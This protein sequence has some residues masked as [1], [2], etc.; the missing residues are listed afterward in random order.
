M[1]LGTRLVSDHQYPTRSA[2]LLLHP[3]YLRGCHLPIFDAL[4]SLPS[5]WHRPFTASFTRCLLPADA[6]PEQLFF[7][8]LAVFQSHPVPRLFSFLVELSQL[9]REML[10]PLMFLPTFRNNL[11]QSFGECESMKTLCS[12]LTSP[13][14]NDV[15][16][17]RGFD[18]SFF[19]QHKIQTPSLT[20][21]ILLAL[22]NLVL[23]CPQAELVSL[24]RDR[25]IDT[26][27]RCVSQ[28]EYLED[29]EHGCAVVA[30]LLRAVQKHT[31][32]QH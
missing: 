31:P 21:V 1:Q 3:F 13:T 25:P 10:V 11:L 26:I 24:M 23:F 14:F 17:T 16:Q 18:I 9:D 5:R 30:A 7:D 6:V 4:P 29:Y 20:S 28:S 19:A 27:I 15:D 2:V 32:F 12:I 8:T 22:H